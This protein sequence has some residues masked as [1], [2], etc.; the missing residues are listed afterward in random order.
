MGYLF[1]WKDGRRLAAHTCSRDSSVVLEIL[2]TLR[3]LSWHGGLL[4]IAFPSSLSLLPPKRRPKRTLVWLLANM[5]ATAVEFYSDRACLFKVQVDP[6]AS[7]VDLFCVLYAA[8]FGPYR[9]FS[10]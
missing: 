9:F 4:H 7:A 1:Q 10:R 5:D 3:V 8:L 6:A 2:H